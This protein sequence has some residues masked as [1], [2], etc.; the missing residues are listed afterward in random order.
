VTRRRRLLGLSVVVLAAIAVGA[1]LLATSPSEAHLPTTSAPGHA[2]VN[3]KATSRA[4]CASA[5]AG[6]STPRLL[7]QLL[8][9]TGDFTHPQALESAAAA[10]V[11]ALEMAFAP[12]VE[13]ETTPATWPRVHAVIASLVSVATRA[14]RLAPIV[15]TDAEGGTVTRL[16]GVLGKLPSPREM[17][18]I[19][20]AAHVEQVAATRARHLKALGILM[21]TA[22]VYDTASP[23]STRVYGASRSF[24]TSP[25]VAAE[26]AD[27][28]ARGLASA[29]VLAV[30]KQFPG[31]GHAS[32][33][34]DFGVATDP[35]LATLR[36]HDLLSFEEAI[37]AK[38]PVMM[39]GNTLVPGLTDGQ[40]AS[41]SGATYTLLRT[42]LGF[43]GLT[44]T[45]TLDVK[46]ISGAGDN[47]QE[48]V[49]AAVE[50]GADMPMLPAPTWQPALGALEHAV[51]T[52]ALPMRV[53]RTRV[54][55]VLV[56]KGV[57]TGS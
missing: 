23:A 7:A 49:V 2:A 45:D 18:A 48:A 15:S 22:P 13:P 41:V 53:V 1:G 12:G 37:A 21:D 39:V 32:A 31:E 11:G 4:P 54:A 34:T 30:A 57:C 33:D 50:A 51:S 3:G 16:A 29:G 24:S 25:A 38:I 27:A 6:W 52:G 36:S 20:S 10:G 8:M 44:I 19:W 14:G 46:A 26:Y 55:H 17:A 56:A 9:L 43:S 42:T 40:P 35:P 5:A 47:T 28:F